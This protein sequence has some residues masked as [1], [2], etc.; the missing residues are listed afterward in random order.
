[1]DLNIEV[2]NGSWQQTLATI[3][4]EV[5]LKLNDDEID[6]IIKRIDDRISDED[7]IELLG[8][9]ISKLTT[10]STDN[11]EI[12]DTIS[13]I[14][15]VI[16]GLLTNMVSLKKDIDSIITRLDSISIVHKTVIIQKPIETERIKRHNRKDDFIKIIPEDI[17]FIVDMNI[18]NG[19]SQPYRIYLGDGIWTNHDRLSWLVSGNR[20]RL[21]Y[22]GNLTSDILKIYESYGIKNKVIIEKSCVSTL[23][24]VPTTFK[25]K[26]SNT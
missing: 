16:S 24:K 6:N 12:K 21:T 25:I 1:M 18:S 15:K 19:Y 26:K 11:I 13:L 7:I 5:R 14:F 20:R 4:N 3:L 22:T 17:T 23:N 9:V 10:L 2:I 8:E